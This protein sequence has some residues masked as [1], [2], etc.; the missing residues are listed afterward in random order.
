LVQREEQPGT[1]SP[2]LAQ[3]EADW[4]ADFEAY[5]RAHIAD[6]ALSISFLA[7]EFSMSESTFLRQVTRITG[8]S[9]K[10][11]L[12]EVRLHAARE[13]LENKTYS[14]VSQVSEKVGY[15]NVRTFTRSFRE[16]FGK[17]PSEV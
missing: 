8:L 9:P 10:Q 3:A 12:Q 2:I 4:L 15:S 7:Q 6:D 14:S 5:I 11:Y 13:M 17:L 16:R 1:A